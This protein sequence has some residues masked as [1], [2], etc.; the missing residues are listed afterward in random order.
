VKR[1]RL[2]FV[3]SAVASI[4][5]VAIYASGGQTQLEGIGLG[6]ALGS[7]GAALVLWGFSLP[8][9]NA[10]EE[11]HELA[12]DPQERQGLASDWD[13]GEEVL[14]RRSMLRW[15]GG[16]LTALGAALIFPIRSLG[17][18]PGKDLFVTPWTKGAKVVDE[19]G[20]PLR[21]GD[22]EVNGVVTVF[23]EGHVGSATAQAL[24]IRVDPGSLEL[25]GRAA[26][27]APDGYVVYSKVCTHAG[28][29]VGLF[30]Q[31]TSQLLC[32]CHQ[33]TF[34]VLTGAQP[35]FGPATRPLP[36]LPL[37]VDSGGFLVALGDFPEP[38]GPGF[39]NRER[40]A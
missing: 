36:Q 17:P 6:I 5:L 18:S 1:A 19:T 35:V 28:C 14:S 21:T 20:T 11:R 8:G 31:G 15:A 30:E 4:S 22:L 39:W 34:N 3:V 25:T 24:L 29:P 26:S 27:W 12:S 23:P 13:S 38:V 16:A 33:S 2:A 9:G 37:S 10:V 32:P 40:G 7:M